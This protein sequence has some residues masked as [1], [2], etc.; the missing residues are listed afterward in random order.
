MNII[1]FGKGGREH[2]LASRFADEK[3]VH[4]VFVYPGNPGMLKTNKIT[5]L[6][7][8]NES[9]LFE[10]IKSEKIELGV[11]GPED[12][13]ASGFADIIR[14]LGLKLVSP[15]KEAAELESS[16]IFSK[17]IMEKYKIPTAKAYECYD[18][19]TGLSLLDHFQ[20]GVVIKLSGLFAGKGVFVADNLTAA[21][22][23]LIEWESYLSSG[24]LIEE[25]L[26][27]FEASMFYL[28]RGTEFIYM[29]EAADH[30]RIFD[31][32][33]G[34]NTGGM[35]CFSPIPKLSDSD[36]QN[37]AMNIVSATLKGLAA[38]NIFFSGILFVGIMMTQ[39]GP[40]VLEYNVRFGDPETQTFLPLIKEGFL[41]LFLD[42]VN[43][44]DFKNNKLKHDGAAV[45]V[46]KATR[47]YPD[48][49]IFGEEVKI[50]FNLDRH[51][52]FAGVTKVSGKLKTSG[53]RVCGL[54]AIGENITS[55]RKNCYA[56]LHQVTFPFEHYRKD[57][58]EKALE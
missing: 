18:L 5:I 28:C 33:L 22:N 30:K 20:D 11:V 52:Y 16:K 7:E 42:F 24:Y 8:L 34:P 14:A 51:F 54:T 32:D 25:K 2:A 46:V 55:A 13:M 47:G 40:M 48:Q 35:G 29:G 43:D 37:I 1:I 21:K 41:D 27:G 12:Y 23:K 45:H 19:K 26:V 57:I 31:E 38:E 3:R 6:N 58:A 4:Q 44:R 17:K 53:G 39:K 56:N 9:Q 49:P 36:R 50:E 10:F 15:T